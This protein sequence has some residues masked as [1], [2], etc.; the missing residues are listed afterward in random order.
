MGRRS[1]RVF[2]ALLATICLAIVLI[3]APGA[4]QFVQGKQAADDEAGPSTDSDVSQR[5]KYASDS[6]E[7]FYY[8]TLRTWKKE[9]VLPGRKELHISAASFARK[10]PD[11]EAHSAAYAGESGVLV[12][13]NEKGWVEYDVEVEDE[14]LYELTIEYAPFGEKDGGS[15]QAVMLGL[16]VNGEYPFREARSVAFERSFRER[17]AELDENGNQLR[18]LLEEAEGWRSKPISDSGGAYALPLQWYLKKGENTVRIEALQ[19]PVA[20]R[21]IT[22]APPSMLPSYSETRARYPSVLS[23]AS[24]IITVEAEHFSYKNSTGI[25]VNYDKDPLT[26][27]RS[28]TAK[29]FNTLGG[30]TWA[31]GGQAVTWDFEVPADG[32]Y[33]LGFRAYQGFRKNLTAFR[34]V[35]IDGRVPFEELASYPFAYSSD[36]KGFVLQDQDHQPY[37]FY[38]S[39]GKHS[40]TLE[41]NY[42]PYTPIIVDIDWMSRELR[43]VAW[44]IRVA[45]GNREDKLRVWNVEKDIPGIT[46]RLAKLQSKLTELTE[47]MV[48]INHATDTV[49]QSFKSAAK[50]IEELLREPDEIPYSQLTIGSLQEKLETQR[51]E[52]MSSPLQVDKLFLAP[53]EQSFPRTTARFLEKMKGSL[54]SLWYSFA[55]KN[56]FSKQKGEELNVWMLWG[57]DYVD[58][59]QQ[60]ADEKFTPKY[61]IKVRV[62]LIQTSDLLVLGKAAG[63]LPDVALGIPEGVPYQMALRNAAFDLSTLPGAQKLLDGYHPGSLLPYYYDGGYYGLPETTNFKVLFYRKDI[64]DELGLKVPNT[65]DDVYSMMPTLLQNEY[66][67]YVDPGDFTY[68]FF[69]NG[70]DLYTPDGLSTALNTPEAFDAFKKWT[71][72][73]NVYG[74]DRQV[75]SFYNQ[76]R[77]GTMPVGVADFSMYMQLLVAAPEILN[78]WGIAPVPGTIRPNGSIV[79]WSGASGNSMMMFKDTPKSKQELAWQFLQWYASDETQ[80]E[81]GLNMEQYRGEEFRW[82]TANVRAFARMPWKKD[83]LNVILEQWKWIKEIPNVPGGYMSTREL[84]FAWNRATISNELAGGAGLENPRISLEKAIKEINRELD[85]KLREF[86]MVDGDGKVLK[87]LDLPQITEPWKGA[88]INAK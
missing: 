68:M 61:G 47:R 26:T 27:P 36:W 71:D 85:R 52:L 83:D 86:H 15:R 3:G 88:E 8:E 84:S 53:A 10:S 58:E 63:I 64:L 23:T 46:E 17:P 22:A 25:Q 80:A 5:A 79:R 55:D 72:L 1:R 40:I 37:E 67:F 54:Q 28:L 48:S 74:M 60:L 87:T 44:D 57:R 14:G 56:Q 33:K 50:D 51:I 49:S 41:V 70:V 34:T 43:S 21:A 20:I 65:W 29:I 35:S 11:A 12:W 31:K 69:Q 82:N 19:Q 78:T 62:N 9:G 59:L 24:D 32:L 42:E 30:Y 7:P 6:L 2:G 4:P 76:F 81:Y 39:K 73:F 38:L 77:R 13:P 18:S 45:T 75:Q 66:N 16:K